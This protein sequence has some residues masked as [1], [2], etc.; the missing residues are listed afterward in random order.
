MGIHQG[1]QSASSYSVI[2]Q[3]MQIYASGQAIRSNTKEGPLPLLSILPQKTPSSAIFCSETKEVRPAFSSE[4]GQSLLVRLAI[5]FFLRA[6]PA[7]ARYRQAHR[8][9]FTF[10]L[11]NSRPQ[12]S[13]TFESWRSSVEKR[14]RQRKRKKAA[15]C[16]LCPFTRERRNFRVLGFAYC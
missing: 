10:H 8:E 16:R 4:P 9:A 6:V 1:E 11:S 14:Q 2:L 7:T 12:P 15:D 3:C 5:S 13:H